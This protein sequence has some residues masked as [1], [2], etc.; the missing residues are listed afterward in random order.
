[1]DEGKFWGRWG[2]GVDGEGE[3]G[4]FEA[5]KAG[6][7]LVT[8]LHLVGDE[9]LRAEGDE[10]YVRLKSVWCEMMGGTVAVD[11]VRVGLLVGMSIFYV[12]R[13]KCCSDLLRKRFFPSFALL[14]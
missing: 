4:C 6:M 1:M 13:R 10:V 9:D 14:G 5:L 7:Y 2:L 12:L 11:V 3:E 8:R